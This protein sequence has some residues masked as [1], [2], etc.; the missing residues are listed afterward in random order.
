MTRPFTGWHMAGILVAFF[1]VVIGVNLVM[2]TSAVRTFGGVV[3]DNSYVASQRFNQWL[4]EARA[5]DA[6]GW[7][8]RARGTPDGV[9]VVELRDARGPIRQASVHAEAEHPLG[10]VRG[11][12]FT[13]TA[14]G[15]GRYAAPH[16]LAAGRW[17][18]RIEARAA[19]REA[20]FVQDVRL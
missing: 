12:S 4:A 15:D 5:Q 8:A 11:R 20:R 13:L 9:L 2:A 10:R 19:G 1:A 16:A 17:R 6:Q 3:V 7:Q 18:I 14:L